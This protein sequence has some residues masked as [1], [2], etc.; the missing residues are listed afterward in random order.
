MSLRTQRSL[1]ALILAGLGVALLYRLWSG[2]LWWYVQGRLVVF[3]LITAPALLALARAAAAPSAATPPANPPQRISAWRLWLVALPVIVGL[4]VPAHPLGSAALAARGL[5]LAV[6]PASA[7]L[8]SVPPTERTVLDWVQVQHASVGANTLAGQ[9]AD[10]SGFVYHDRRLRPGEFIVSRFVLAC[11]AASALGVGMLVR[12]PAAAGMPPNAWVRV[13]G[14]VQAGD[15][16][17]QPI[18]AIDATRVEGVDEP[19]WPYLYP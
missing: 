5:N 12:W 17:G 15:F 13:R 11:C 14:T 16:G 18:P 9:P 1:Q 2:T 19:L 4:L 6:P 3:V 10:V 7:T 8:L